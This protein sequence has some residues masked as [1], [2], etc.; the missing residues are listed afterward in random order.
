M[1]NRK[2]NTKGER[3]FVT[4]QS[5]KK[6]KKHLR[7]DFALKPEGWKLPGQ[8]ETHDISNIDETACHD[9]T[10][11]KGRWINEDGLEQRLIV[12]YSIKYRNYQ[13]QIRERQLARAMQAIESGAK[14]V[15]RRN[16][17]DFKRFIKRTAVTA[18]GEVANRKV[19]VIDTQ[20]VEEESRF[21]GFYAVC[22]NLE[23]N[24]SEII[25]INHRRWE[26][27][28]CFRIMKSEFKARPVFL[29]KDQ[30]IQAHFIT[31]FTA[32]VL[33][34]FLEKKLGEK[35]SCSDM[36]HTL[37]D[38]NFVHEH[39]VGYRPTYTRSDITDALHSVFGFRTDFKI[40]PNRHM[41]YIFKKTMI[42]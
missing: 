18:N 10:F 17:N 7:D 9:M 16:P 11:Y 42:A 31:C 23:G 13:R 15:D 14:T 41:K 5:I 36:I 2:F 32:L 28:E 19:Y 24:A 38:M 30:R 12:T 21:D 29:R 33:F 20:A 22:T 4:V 40:L 37:R 35:Y 34:R 25:A 6:L 39:G 27:E 8:K 1:Q 26:I 3:A